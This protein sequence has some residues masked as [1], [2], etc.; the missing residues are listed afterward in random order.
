MIEIAI[1]D[2]F[3]GRHA[4]DRN[5]AKFPFDV[6]ERDLNL[7]SPAE[8]LA[9]ISHQSLHGVYIVGIASDEVSVVLSEDEK[10]HQ[11]CV[12]FRCLRC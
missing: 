1:T 5:L 7:L 8:I 6:L 10:T 2:S 12:G 4:D 11:L 3:L 9:L